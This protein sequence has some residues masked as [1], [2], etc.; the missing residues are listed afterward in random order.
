MS[1]LSLAFSEPWILLALAGAPLLFLLLRVTPPPPQRVAFPPLRL[2]LDLKKPDATPA[3]TPLWLLLLR[4]ALAILI[5]LVM[6][7]PILSPKGLIVSDKAP[8]LLL[9][10]DFWP[11]APDWALRIK[12]AEARLEQ[13]GRSGEPVAVMAL[14]EPARAPQL[15]EFSSALNHL[16]A[17]TP[18]PF[19]PPRVAALPPVT[20]FL[21]ANKGAH[22]LWLSDGLAESDG[23]DFIEKLSAVAP[24]VEVLRSPRA[25]RVI[26][27]ADNGAQAMEIKVL[28]AAKTEEAKGNVRAFDAKGASLGDAP[29]DLGDGLETKAR[30]ELPIQLRNEAARLEIAGENSAGGAFLL[31]AGARRRRVGLVSGGAAEQPF[32]SPLHFLRD[33]LLPFADLREPKPGDVDPVAHLIDDGVDVLVLADASVAAPELKKKLDDFLAA[34]GV[35]LRFAGPRLASKA[36]DFAP[37]KLRRGGRTLGGALSWE[38]PKPLAPFDDKSPFFG[39]AAPAE[40]TVTRQVLAEPEEGLPAK[41]WARLADGT[42]LV[43][44]ERR[45]PGLLVLFHVTADS[46]WSNLPLSGLF[47]DMLRKIVNLSSL[48]GKSAGGAEASQAAAPPLQT[49]DGFGRLGA[50]SA[51][52]KPL[53]PKGLAAPD[54]SHPPGFYGAA[55]APRALNAV[56]SGWR[57][58]PLDLQGLK[59]RQAELTEP[60]PIDL[61][62]P[63]LILAFLLA[64]ADSLALLLLGGRWRRQA[65][66]ALAT[67]ALVVVFYGASPIAP[68]HAADHPKI[69]QKDIDAALST[70]LAYVITG[71]ARADQISREGLS[72]LSETLAQRTALVPGAPQAL[73]PA[74]DELAFYPLIY[75]PIAPDRPQ[76]GAEV[77]RKIGAYMKQGGLVLFDTRDGGMQFEGRRRTPA[78][79]WL[80]AFLA[81]IDLPPLEVAPKDHVIT[82]TF[83]LLKNFVGRTESGP[84]YIEALPPETEAE[85]H[86][87]RAG[88][89][90]SPV[91]IVSND[92]AAAW[93]GDSLGEGLYPLEPGG[94]R[95]REMA[96]RGGVNI[97]MYTLT[98]NYKADQVH[99]HELLERLGH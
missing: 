79:D 36:D 30:L 63:L 23:R 33:A 66:A 3:R 75:W 48:V 43:T 85:N 84:T 53:P 60:Q 49:L 89:S 19:L 35:I 90:V 2:I 39:L 17:M 29:F 14:S 72:S 92:L 81:D 52:A 38:R 27:A 77:A 47:V 26:A 82:K 25:A 86:P 24:D 28:R 55:D 62:P 44:A 54:E 40:V 95:Q 68:V 50:P 13:Q 8:L 46:G 74:R 98:G 41:T 5:V 56:A 12:A 71:D 94:Q 73:D 78:Q 18:K 61:R 76:P 20:Q 15:E 11:A 4:M 57:P 58:V 70:K 91:I 45:G 69:T 87:A 88:D 9:V 97:V 16:R 64:L 37:V 21:Q 32:L 83:Y 7:G 67:F 10:D 22:V 42:P 6:A 59:V 31:D 93:A 96:L 99:V 51:L 80:R 65:G 1:L 34:G